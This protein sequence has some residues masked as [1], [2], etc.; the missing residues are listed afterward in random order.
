VIK[1]PEKD[2]QTGHLGNG[3]PPHCRPPREK[4]IEMR[5]T[6]KLVKSSLSLGLALGL[7]VGF[8]SQTAG[9]QESATTTQKTKQLELSVVT[10]RQKYKRHGKI[11]ITA[12]LTNTNY[13][14]D[15]FVY[16]ALGWGYLASLTYTITDTSGK[17]I[18]PK[19][20]ADDLT[21][22]IPHSDTTFFV[23]LAP[24]HFLGTNY[25]ETLDRLNLKKPGKYS[26]F[27]EYHC[28]ISTADVDLRNFWSKE[29]GTLKS[30]VVSIEVVR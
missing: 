7:A 14:K 21:F 17:R 6:T 27:V 11:K 22:P 12:M 13:V 16:R 30:N 5:R 18:Q 3:K 9:R 26:I 19:V 8:A 2:A 15:I 23:K 20:L 28:P 29:D 4:T 10:D 1:W 25:I 24:N